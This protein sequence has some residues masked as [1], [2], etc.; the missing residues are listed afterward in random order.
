M[1]T[2]D[3]FKL[4]EYYR[5]LPG[6]C[7]DPHF[8]AIILEFA[9][10]ESEEVVQALQEFLWDILLQ[11]CPSSVS[12]EKLHIHTLQG[13]RRAGTNGRHA[14]TIQLDS[15]VTACRMEHQKKTRQA[16]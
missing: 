12:V 15:Y 11:A 3:A 1:L 8:S 13:T 2:A 7:V 9:E 4:L 6:C 5:L 16:P 14:K 10:G